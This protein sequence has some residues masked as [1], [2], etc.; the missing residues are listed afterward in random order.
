[1]DYPYRF[2]FLHPYNVYT[3]KVFLNT[4]EI[5]EATALRLNIL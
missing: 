4:N 3:E 2:R 5:I 1:M